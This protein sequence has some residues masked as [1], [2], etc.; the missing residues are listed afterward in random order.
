MNINVNTAAF[1][2]AEPERSTLYRSEPE[3]TLYRLW[4]VEGGGVWERAHEVFQPRAEAEKRAIEIARQHPE[5]TYVVMQAVSA[6][7]TAPMAVAPV[8]LRELCGDTE[9]V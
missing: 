2:S 3:R 5:R 6:F 1:K 7:R 9:S 4:C 8:P